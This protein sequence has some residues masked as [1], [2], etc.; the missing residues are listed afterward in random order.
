MR[1][2]STNPRARGHHTQD[3]LVVKM[4]ISFTGNA[5]SYLSSA[6]DKGIDLKDWIWHEQVINGERYYIITDKI[7]S[8]PVE[9]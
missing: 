9:E 5:I 4:N 6:T 2:T 8:S 1:I 3:G 7:V